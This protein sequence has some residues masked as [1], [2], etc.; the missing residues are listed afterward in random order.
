MGNEDPVVCRAYPWTRIMDPLTLGRLWDNPMGNWE[1]KKEGGK[2]I[3]VINN[4]AD[5]KNSD[6][7]MNVSNK[8]RLY[9][10]AVSLRLAFAHIFNL[11]EFPQATM[12]FCWEILGV[13]NFFFFFGF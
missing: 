12:C 10:T 2:E 4:L 6:C 8:S 9:R 5:P 7:Q 11:N 13:A 1:T 3:L